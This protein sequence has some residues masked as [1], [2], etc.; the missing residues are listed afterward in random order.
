MMNFIVLAALLSTSN[1]LESNETL[2]INS[3]QRLTVDSQDTF[4][5][6]VEKTSYF[7][8]YIKSEKALDSVVV[9]DENGEVVKTLISVP[10]AEL[11]LFW[12]VEKPGI[13]HIEI[14]AAE[15]CAVG[16]SILLNALDLKDN[17]YVSPDIPIISP[18]IA[19][20]S[21]QLEQGNPAAEQEFWQQVFQQGGAPLIEHSDDDSTLITFLYRGHADNVRVL[22]TPYGGHAHLSQLGDTDIWFRS[23][24]V[25]NSTRL[26]YRIAP[27]VP[28]L[29]DG[30]SREQR[31]AVL[32]TIKPDPLN[33]KP[34]LGK[35]DN[36]SSSA[37][38]VTLKTWSNDVFTQQSGNPKGTIADHTYVSPENART[39]K[40][41]I[42]QPNE[43]YSI[44]RDSPVL[45]LFDGDA[46]LE[47]VPTPLIL[48]NLIANEKVPAMRAIFVNT[49][50]PSMRAAE[51]TPNKAYADFLADELMP[52]LCDT[53]N[54]CPD[55]KNT[56][57]SGSS[58]GGLASMY[59]ALQH[60]DRF[61]KVLSQ[62]GSFWWAPQASEIQS[63]HS[64]WMADVVGSKAKK[65]LEIY[66]TV[67]QFEVEPESNSI[68][69]TNQQL[70]QALKSKGYKVA[71]QKGA[72]GHDYFSWRAMLAGGLIALFNTEK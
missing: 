39:R 52:W 34:M 55:A 13:Y 54:I 62:S 16:V 1:V 65:D 25:P 64:N 53:Q 33:F 3:E 43:I 63:S 48:D 11:D 26:S 71:I 36:L 10:T 14:V 46:Y 47:R 42:Y 12:Y 35:G 17:Q 21:Q 57:L 72:S 18:I 2:S 15:K 44:S 70:Y 29:L 31:R 23:Y 56:V 49:P 32:A 22:G 59:I 40:I 51:L 30:E 7:R 69:A 27:N 66:L 58:F 67:G 5:L 20:T 37:S 45:I 24:Q 60:P 38:T 8:G 61:G 28:Q 50:M 41:S 19:H 68:L 6:R 4:P 9:K